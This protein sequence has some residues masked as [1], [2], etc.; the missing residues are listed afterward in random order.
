M[1]FAIPAVNST[2]T[3][4]DVGCGDGH[5]LADLPG[6]RYGV[7][8]D[9]AAIGNGLR[10]YPCLFLQIGRAERLPYPSGFA[11]L[12]MSKAA[13]VYTNLDAS[14]SEARRVVKLGGRLY[15]TMHEEGMQRGWLKQA[16]KDRS[17]KRVLDHLVYIYPAS[18]FYQF[19][20]ISLARPWSGTYETFQTRGRLRRH[21]E[22]KGF[23]V[24]R[25][26][27]TVRHW[28][29]EAVAV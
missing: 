28:I 25:M 14:L 3:V 6:T 2:D 21:L 15:L 13:L 24:T 9:E 26:E 19:T 17:W 7:D 1:H 12:V 4:V 29:V 23:R 27:R 5:A 8:I 10:A 11:D 20:G 16:I 18:W 22:A